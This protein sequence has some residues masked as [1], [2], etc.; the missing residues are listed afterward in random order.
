MQFQKKNLDIA[1]TDKWAQLHIWDTLGQEKFKSMAPIFFRRSVGAFLVYDV[2]NIESFHALQSWKDQIVNNADGTIIVMLLGN[3]CDLPNKVVTYEMG[4]EFARENGFGFMEVS[5]KSD[6]GIKAA[7]N[8]LVAN[9]YQKRQGVQLPDMAVPEK[10]EEP[11]KL[12]AAGDAAAAGKKA[13]KKK[14]GC[15]GG[16]K[17]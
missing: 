11:V 9:I 14:G 6:I 10:K 4:Q 12:T 1:G 8:G 17:D 3:K 16:G 15:C 5:A 7:F 13:E 2:T